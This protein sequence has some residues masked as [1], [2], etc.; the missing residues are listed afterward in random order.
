MS[1]KTEF[2]KEAEE[3]T[4][5]GLVSEIDRGTRSSPRVPVIEELSS[6]VPRVPVPVLQAVQ[7]PGSVLGEELR[8][9]RAKVRNLAQERALKCFAMISA[10]PGEGKSTLSLGL[11][12]TMA[13]EPN[14]RVLLVEADLRRPA[15]EGYLGLPRVSG[16]SE[17][18]S[19]ENASVGVR[20]IGPRGFFL[21]SAGLVPLEQPERLGSE[22]MDGFL[23]A[24]RQT[25]DVI[26]LD[27]PPLVPVADS[28][29]IQ[30]LVDGYFCVVR[31]RHTPRDVLKRAL[32]NLKPEK[33][34]GLVLNN[35]RE[36]LST[37]QRNAYRQY[38]LKDS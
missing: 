10:G 22:K 36:I 11:A 17:W 13:Q 28:I 8:L 37:Y 29:L 6:I 35:H 30:D 27:C 34:L 9:L 21:L 15:L 23:Q 3:E 26:V 5:S 12:A 32:S 1:R 18:L 16:L 24:A 2:A 31:A 19:G 33:I 4:L 20:C 7:T 25:F 38:G 14:R